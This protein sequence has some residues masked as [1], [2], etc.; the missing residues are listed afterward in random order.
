MANGPGSVARQELLM[1][2]TEPQALRPQQ[3]FRVHVI[4]AQSGQTIRAV[5]GSSVA[6]AMATEKHPTEQYLGRSTICGCTSHNSDARTGHR[7]TDRFP[8]N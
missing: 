1:E 4:G 7:Q 8:N 5:F 2:P 3:T 6:G